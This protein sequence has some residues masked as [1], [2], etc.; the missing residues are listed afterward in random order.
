MKTGMIGENGLSKASITSFHLRWI[1][2]PGS[3][4]HRLAVSTW[5]IPRKLSSCFNM[6]KYDMGPAFSHGIVELA[7]LHLAVL[8]LAAQ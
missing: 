4:R 8:V 6:L 2:S 7:F 3:L 1:V 5:L